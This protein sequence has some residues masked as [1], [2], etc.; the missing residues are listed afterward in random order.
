MNKMNYKDF[1]IG[2]LSCFVLFILLNTYGCGRTLSRLGLGDQEIKLPDDFQQAISISMH[3]IS[4]SETVKDLTYINDKGEIRS[5]EYRDKPWA[6]E[7]S[8][9]W[10]KKK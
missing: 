8:I 10:V 7:G 6:L 5:I 2:F 3:R 4:G 1:L 9:R